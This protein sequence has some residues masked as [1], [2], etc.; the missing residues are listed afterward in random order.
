MTAGDDRAARALFTQAFGNTLYAAAPRFALARALAAESP[1]E[2]AGLVAESDGRLVGVAVFGLVAGAEGAAKMHGM[3]VAPDAQR[4]GIARELIEAFVGEL[5]RR[6]ARFVLVEFPDAPE[7]AG[8]R[9]LLQHAKFAE[10]S[11]V[12]DYFRDGIA[13]VFLRRELA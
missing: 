7:L 13:L 4:H 8:G 9:T 5:Q 2:S 12:K 3:A 6:G 1:S 10:E 11:R